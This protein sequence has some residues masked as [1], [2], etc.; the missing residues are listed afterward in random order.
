MT[1]SR[2]FHEV[3]SDLRASAADLW[4]HSTSVEGI[5][6]ELAP[7]LRM[8]VPRGL[9]AEAFVSTLGERTTEPVHLGRSYILLLGI[10]PVDWDDL[11][12]EEIDPGRRFLERSKLLSMR[13]WQH[14]RIIVPHDAGA[15]LTDR[16]EG[17]PRALVPGRIAERVVATIFKHRHAR[18]VAR[19]GER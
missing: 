14:E 16:L 9:D 8:T 11:V 2:F 17:D 7:W 18:L 3:S 5:S 15:R 13:R 10:I 1:H 12:I 4:R 6:Y 19:F